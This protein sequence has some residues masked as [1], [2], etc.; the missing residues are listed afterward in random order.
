V[1]YA[2]SGP[3]VVEYFRVG[4]W[5]WVPQQDDDNSPALLCADGDIFTVEEGGRVSCTAASPVNNNTG[6]GVFV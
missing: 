3:V 1:G 5:I 6:F 2:G 4:G